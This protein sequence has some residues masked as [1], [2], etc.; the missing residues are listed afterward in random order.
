MKNNRRLAEIVAERLSVR[1]EKE[2]VDTIALLTK[3]VLEE[4]GLWGNDDTWDIAMDVASR[5]HI[6]AK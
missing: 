6:E 5:I 4:N 1:M 2:I 3:E